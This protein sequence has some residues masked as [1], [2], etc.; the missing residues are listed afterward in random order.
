MRSKA[1][2]HDFFAIN[3]ESYGLIHEK[4]CVYSQKFRIYLRKY[5]EKYLLSQWA[6][7]VVHV[8]MYHW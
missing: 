7:A 3:R 5:E 8:Y 2:L 6:A 4:I 1:L